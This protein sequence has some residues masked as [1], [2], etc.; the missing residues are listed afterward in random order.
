MKRNKS[1]TLVAMLHRHAFTRIG[2]TVSIVMV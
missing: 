1:T 2:W